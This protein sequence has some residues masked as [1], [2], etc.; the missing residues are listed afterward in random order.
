MGLTF[1]QARDRVKFTVMLMVRR[2]DYPT[3]VIPFT[4]FTLGPSGLTMTPVS[5]TF[6][7]DDMGKRQL[8]DIEFPTRTREAKASMAFFA[9]SAV[10][11][12]DESTLDLFSKG[13]EEGIW[14]DCATAFTREVWYAKVKRRRFGNPMLERPWKLWDQPV[15]PYTE[16]FMNPTV[17][18]LKELTSPA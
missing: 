8:R 3:S 1:A 9:V 7:L 16:G 13:S 15:S 14:I 2:L 10:W 11:S 6:F 5:D 12:L 4:F 18:A 17:D